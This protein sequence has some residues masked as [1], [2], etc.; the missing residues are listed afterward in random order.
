MHINQSVCSVA[1]G[2]D[3][4]QRLIVPYRQQGRQ[5]LQFVLITKPRDIAEVHLL[6]LLQFLVLTEDILIGE[7]KNI[8]CVDVQLNL[9]EFVDL[10]ALEENSLEDFLDVEGFV[11][12]E[13]EV[14]F[15]FEEAV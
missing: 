1:V 6:G 3:L 10:Y 7:V 11:G 15:F 9:V 13:D 12:C 4:L 14:D 5:S 8:I 2:E